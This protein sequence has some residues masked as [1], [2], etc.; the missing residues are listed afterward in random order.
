MLDNYKNPS[1][2]LPDMDYFTKYPAPI[3]EATFN[4]HISPINTT[5]PF[6]GPLL[7]WLCRILGAHYTLEI[8]LAQGWSSF[9]MASAVTDEGKTSGLEG[10]YYGCDVGDKTELFNKMKARG[11][12]CKF[13]YK[14][15]LLIKPEDL[16]NHKL[17]LVFQDGWHSTEYVM[18]EL[19]LLLPYLHDKG[20]GYWVMHDIYSWCEEGF[21]KV[22]EA[23]EWEYIRFFRN[24]G[25]AVLRN[26]KNYDHNHIHWP[27]GPQ[28]PAY[29]NAK[30]IVH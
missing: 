27:T 12:N 11:V 15:S 10:M 24:Y 2:V 14:D 29:P 18:D 26:M 28:K 17:H 9:F 3:F 30:E 13:I 4:Q 22:L 20:N 7:Y 25:L 23:N 5:T 16:D 8:G 21:K 1:F 19:K 6:Y